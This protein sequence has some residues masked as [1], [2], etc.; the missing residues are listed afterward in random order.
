MLAYLPLITCSMNEDR[1]YLHR[2]GVQEDKDNTTS[3]DNQME[4]P[5]TQ[6]TKKNA[7]IFC[8]YT[9]VI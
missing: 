3:E 6:A 7:Q 9:Q 8:H 1:V 4:R 5:E 2:E